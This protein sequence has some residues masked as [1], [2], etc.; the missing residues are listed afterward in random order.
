MSNITSHVLDTSKGKPAG[1][2]KIILFKNEDEEWITIAGGITNVDG[3]IT[4]LLEKDVIPAPGIYKLKFETHEYF[5][6]DSVQTFYPFIEI[7]FEIKDEE[8]YHVP[9]LLN[10]YGYSTYRGS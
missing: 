5:G 9:L 6:K 2:I 3:R 7:I 8:H 4:D 10:P 1:G